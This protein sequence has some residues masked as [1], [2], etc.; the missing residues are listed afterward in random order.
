MPLP[1]LAL[2][3]IAGGALGQD[4]YNDSRTRDSQAAVAGLLGRAP[5]TVAAG[6]EGPNDSGSG[7]MADPGNIQ[8]QLEFARGIMGL[9]NRDRGAAAG[10]FGDIMA[11]AGQ[12]G[13][14]REG[15][16]QQRDA[17]ALAESNINRRWEMGELR[18]SQQFE[19]S[20]NLARERFENDKAQFGDNAAWE[21]FKFGQQQLLAQQQAARAANADR[22][23]AESHEWE[24]A[25]FDERKAPDAVKLQPGYRP[26]MVTGPNGAQV[27]AAPI[28]GTPD[29][30]KAQTEVDQLSVAR[31]NI[32][33][34]QDSLKKHGTEQVGAGAG[35][36]KQLWSRV[37]ASIGKLDELGT[38]QPGDL[39]RLKNEI[40]DP[41]EWV[42]LPM[43]TSRV[44]A[45]LSGLD[46]N[47]KMRQNNAGAKYRGY[48][49]RGLM[50]DAPGD[51]A[52]AGRDKPPAGSK[53]LGAK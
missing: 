40:P 46:E 6:V 48:G 2:L 29:W 5:S 31:A 18:I 35:E 38:L 17:A 13:M 12:Q 20:Q 26:V 21:R 33:K 24:R 11:R 42:R 14:T 36:Q 52:G 16:A 47:F 44:N 7:L 23:A 8:R 25:K 3:G 10:I 15:W 37:M 9:N 53:P 43:S 27:V 51:D 45:A 34:F 49:L 28:E 30:V 22:R 39:E 19:Q 41:T 50:Q 1:L 32:Q 4:V